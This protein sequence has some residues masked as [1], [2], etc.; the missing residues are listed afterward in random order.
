MSDPGWQRIRENVWE[1]A[2]YRIAASRVDRQWRY[3]VFAPPR[4]EKEFDSL[5]MERYDLG[6]RVP[7]HREL[8]ECVDDPVAARRLVQQQLSQ[9]AAA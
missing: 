2:G 6:A 1:R 8:I 9:P 5:C 4:P 3:C 7:A